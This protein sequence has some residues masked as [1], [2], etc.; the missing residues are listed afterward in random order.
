M[1]QR[2]YARV[3]WECGYF[4]AD[5]QDALR[6]TYAEVADAL[7]PVQAVGGWALRAADTERQQNA[8]R[9]RNWSVAV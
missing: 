6:A 4:L 8:A 2:R 7:A 9:L 5:I 3:M 1:E